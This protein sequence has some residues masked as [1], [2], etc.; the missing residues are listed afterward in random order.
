MGTIAPD[1]G[2]KHRNVDMNYLCVA[3]VDTK[4]ASLDEAGTIPEEAL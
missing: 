3:D 2:T 1:K 4:G